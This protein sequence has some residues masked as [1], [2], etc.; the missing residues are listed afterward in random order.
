[1]HAAVKDEHGYVRLNIGKSNARRGDGRMLEHRWVMEQV[2]GRPL[3]PE[4]NV[5]HINGD[6]ADNRPENL[7]LWIKK[8]PQGQR[9]SDLIRYFAEFHTEAIKAEVSR[10]EHERR[11][12]QLRLD[13]M[14]AAHITEAS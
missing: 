5:H 10:V 4:E 3:Q 6:R 14:L 8:Q 11:T 2:I 12:G 1:M 9:V 7:E 13:E